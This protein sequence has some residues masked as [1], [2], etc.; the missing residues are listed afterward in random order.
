MHR[1]GNRVYIQ[2]DRC[3]D[4]SQTALCDTCGNRRAT[5]VIRVGWLPDDAGHDARKVD[6]VLTCASGNLEYFAVVR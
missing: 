1:P 4:V 2:F 5:V 6:D 3:M